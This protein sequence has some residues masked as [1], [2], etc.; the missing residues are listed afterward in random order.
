MIEGAP[1]EVLHG[2]EVAA[3][4]LVDIVGLHDVG[5]AEAR[6]HARLFEEHGE[7]LFVLDE[8]G[9]QLLERDELA[10]A[11]RPL[12]GGHVDDP[13]SA[14]RHLAEQSVATDNVAECVSLYWA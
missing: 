7:E 3:V 13:H 5:V 6:R 4:A 11:G 10:E 2:D 1:L 12:R 9:A 8:V 14:A